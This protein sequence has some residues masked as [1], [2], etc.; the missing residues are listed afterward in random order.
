MTANLRVL[1]EDLYALVKGEC[2]GILNEDSGGDADL[3]L[4]IEQAL[5]E[6]VGKAHPDDIAVDNFAA[7]MKIKLAKSRAKGRSGWET[8]GAKHLSQLLIDHVPK[9]DPVDVANFA[10]MLHQ[11]NQSIQPFSYKLTA[12]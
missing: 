1:L 10:M 6:P 3:A 7:A 11:T 8:A 12:Y 9:G 5:A 2:P 4:N